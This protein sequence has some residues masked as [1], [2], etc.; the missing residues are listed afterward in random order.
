MS[1]K[2]IIICDYPS[3]YTFPSFGFGSAEKRIWSF[4]RTL[5]NMNEFEVIV[6][7]PLWLPEYLP[8]A[9]HFLNGAKSKVI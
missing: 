2:K 3:K 8:K 9:K 6:T 5:S 4:A 7:G 1:K